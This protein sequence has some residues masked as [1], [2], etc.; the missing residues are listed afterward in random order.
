MPLLAGMQGLLI[1]LGIDAFV[2]F[3]PR[4]SASV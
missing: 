2:S 1:G 3:R 4:K